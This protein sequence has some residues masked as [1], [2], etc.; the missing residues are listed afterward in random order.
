MSED[1]QAEPAP[2]D[3][4]PPP[5]EEPPSPS[6]EDP[7]PPSR[8]EAVKGLRGEASELSNG[9][10][11]EIISAAAD[12][13]AGA[14]NLNLFHGD[15]I[16]D[17]DFVAGLGGRVGARRS[18]RARTEP[19][20]VI[21]A[22]EYFVAPPDFCDGVGRLQSTSLLVMADAAATGRFT[23]ALATLRDV[24]GKDTNVYRVTNSMLGNPNWRIPHP[25]SGYLVVDTA[26]GDGKFAAGKL[27]DDW[28]TRISERLLEEESYLVVVTGPV[29]GSL[30]TASRRMEFVVE[31]LELP[32]PAEIV[33]RRVAGELPWLEPSELEDHLATNG[34][35][36]L[37]EERDDPHFATRVASAVV[38]AVRTGEDIGKVVGKLSNPE[39]QVREWLSRSPDTADVALVLATAVLEDA[40]YL[41]VA[42]AA[43]ALYRQLST[44]S[45]TL[46]LRYLRRILAE[47]GWL[48]LVTPPTGDGGVSRLR[49]RSAHLRVAVLGVTWVELDGARTKILEW[50]KGLAEHNDVEVR[51]RTAQAAG[52]L[53]TNDFEHGLHKYLLPWAASKTAVLRQSAAHGLNVAGTIGGNAE[54]A[55]SHIEQWAEFERSTRSPKLP[56]TAGLAVGGRLGFDDPRRALLVL[57]TLV[58]R[59]SWELL[60]PVAISTKS[61][62][63]AGRATEVLRALLEWAERSDDEEATVKVLMTFSF[64]V[65]PEDGSGERPLLMR[66]ERKHRDVLPELWGRA[67]A[68]S[69]AQKLARAA[70]RSWIRYADH[71]ETVSSAVLDVLVGIADRGRA[72]LER[73]LRLLQSWAED[74]YAPSD[75]A[76]EFHDTLVDL[77]KEAS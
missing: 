56:I 5:Q 52:I 76:T 1:K 30:A 50:L 58:H 15:I 71:D 11:T 35:A 39:D 14:G 28:L 23:R 62:L 19:Q 69:S 49:F 10:F 25:R 38:E 26:S 54:A 4:A 70:L 37:L 51:A 8:E 43:I 55:W 6:K 18:S 44:S 46:T 31:E 67:L 60:E 72:D 33:R 20:D 2:N 75:K 22:T 66:E 53:A 40:G 17:G 68:D 45:A 41:H 7:A 16:V 73:V 27:T 48:E 61:L 21:K 13:L 32:D 57:R 34:L 9:R 64:A 47:R 29:T 12:R 63:Q 3:P 77:E 36:E 74:P 24:V 59:D 42:D 65:L